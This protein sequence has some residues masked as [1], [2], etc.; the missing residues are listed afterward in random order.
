MRVSAIRRDQGPLGLASFVMELATE[1]VT[2][3][4]GHYQREGLPLAGAWGPI[5]VALGAGVYVART[6]DV[7]F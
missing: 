1:S 7:S 5:L 6:F 4:D 3:D 2:G